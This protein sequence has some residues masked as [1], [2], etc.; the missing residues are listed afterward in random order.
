MRSRLKLL[1][2]AGG[3]LVCGSAEEGLPILDLR[4]EAGQRAADMHRAEV[5]YVSLADDKVLDGR[6]KRVEAEG[7]PV[8]EVDA[9]QPGRPA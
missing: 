6:H 3:N 4:A 8:M 7:L 5:V 9:E 1:E 2:E